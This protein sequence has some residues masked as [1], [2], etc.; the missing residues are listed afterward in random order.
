MEISNEDYYALK[1]QVSTLQTQVNLM[2]APKKTT[3]LRDLLKEQVISRVT[4]LDNAKPIFG[5]SDFNSD[6]WNQAFLLLAKIIHEP[7]NLFYMDTACNG[8]YRARPYIRSLDK[9][10]RLKKVSDLTP[11]QLEVSVQ[12][13]D[14]LIPIYNRYFKM[15]HQKVMF[16]PTGRGDYEPIGVVDEDILKEEEE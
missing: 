1:T 11:E 15:L 9:R 10:G 6:A 3:K 7:S 13:L 12:M 16:D 8:P 2:Q 5:Y 14:E 4:N